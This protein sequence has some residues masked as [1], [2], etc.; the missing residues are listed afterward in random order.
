MRKIKCLIIDDDPYSIT[1]L[2][3]HLI[4]IPQL[5][6]IASYTDPVCALASITSEMKIDILFL[7][8]DMPQVNGLELAPIMRQRV[9]C[10]IL[11]SAHSKYLLEGFSVMADHFLLKP[12]DLMAFVKATTAVIKHYLPNRQWHHDDDD[13]I[14]FVASTD[15]TK[16]RMLKHEILFAEA[17]NN[18]IKFT[19]IK[20]KHQTYMT[21]KQLKATFELDNR[22]MQVHKS[23]IVNR[24][25]VVYIKG[26]EVIFANNLKAPLGRAYK[27][28]FQ[29]YVSAKLLLS[30]RLRSHLNE[31]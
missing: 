1:T 13:E 11:V 21:M 10:I 20:D 3:H 18:Y 22:F 29:A 12:V 28:A 19:T 30:D 17:N 27:Q 24:N 31:I 26:N 4:T 5:E 9:R 8:I 14:L 7:D 25:M 23:F 15:G 2:N 16:Q 6:L